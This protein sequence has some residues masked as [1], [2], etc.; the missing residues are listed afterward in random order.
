MEES[1]LSCYIFHLSFN[2]LENTTKEVSGTNS[3]NT[4]YGIKWEAGRG[5]TDRQRK[6][7]KKRYVV[8]TEAGGTALGHPSDPSSLQRGS[9]RDFPTRKSN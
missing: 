4:I 6:T 8:C 7:S 3:S 1:P 5:M 2:L 9:C